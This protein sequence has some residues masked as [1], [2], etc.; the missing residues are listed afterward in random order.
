MKTLDSIDW[1]FLQGVSRQKVNELASCE[2]IDGAQDVILAGPIGTG[3]TM[4]ANAVGLE[5]T[6]RRLT[7]S[8]S[9]QR[10]SFEN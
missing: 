2:F 6:R 1:E 3:K 8:T 10:I 4:I 7:S 5:A 9:E